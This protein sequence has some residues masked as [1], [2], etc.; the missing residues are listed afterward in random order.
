M[1]AILDFNKYH[2]LKDLDILNSYDPA[3]QYAVKLGTSVP[4]YQIKYEKKNPLTCYN[5]FCLG[6]LK[7]VQIDTCK[8]NYGNGNYNKNMTKTAKVYW[9]NI[10]KPKSNYDKTAVMTNILSNYHGTKKWSKTK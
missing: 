5:D 10:N 8:K 1:I 3:I 6:H 4:N 7:F 9:S 2:S